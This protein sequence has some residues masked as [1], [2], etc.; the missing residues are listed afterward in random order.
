MQNDANAGITAHLDDPSL[1]P[2]QRRRV[3]LFA[4]VENAVC[5]RIEEMCAAGGLEVADTAVLVVAP[6]ANDMVFGDDMGNGTSVLLGHRLRVYEFLEAALPKAPH[7][8]FDP[9]AD[10]LEPAPVRCV[11]VLVLDHES[12]TVMSYGTF[13]TVRMGDADKRA[14]A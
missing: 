12:L 5:A 13:V 8:P 9:Y 2:G 1:T 7:A 14:Q 11:R 3:A 10:L 4:G 6:S